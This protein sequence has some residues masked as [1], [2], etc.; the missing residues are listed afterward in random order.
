MSKIDWQNAVKAAAQTESFEAVGKTIEN[1][2]IPLL[3]DVATKPTPRFI[4]GATKLIDDAQA[5]KQF[6]SSKTNPISELTDVFNHAIKEKP[7]AISLFATPHI[8]ITIAK[9]RAARWLNAAL[10]LEAKIHATAPKSQK[11]NEDWHQLLINLTSSFGAICGGADY[12]TLHYDETDLH[13]KRLASNAFK[14][15]QEEGLLSRSLDPAAGSG[16]VESLT[17]QFAETVWKKLGNKTPLPHLKSLLPPTE[18]T[19]SDEQIEVKNFYTKNDLPQEFIES[20]PGAEPFLRGPYAAM[21]LTR[22]WTIR[23]YAGFSTAEDSNAFY[24]HALK[25][26]QKGLSVAFDLPTHRGFD[27]DNKQVANDVGMAGVA[28]DCLEDMRILFDKIPLDKVS[29]SMTMNG[30]V[31]PIMALYI[32]AAAEQNVAPEQLAG[33]IQNDIFKEFMV[34]NTYIY[35]PKESIRIVADIFEYASKNMPKFNTISIS[36]YHMQEA[37]ATKDLELAYTLADGIEYVR[38]GLKTGMDIDAFAHRLSFFWCIG[39]DFFME[40]AKMRAARVL[41]AEIMKGFGAKKEKSLALRTHCQTS[42]WSLTSKDVFN[43]VAR[44]CLE[45]MAAASGGTQSLHT[46]ALD[47]AMALPSDFSAKVARETQIFLQKET[48]LCATIDG[49]GG[50]YY[51]ERLTAD[52][53]GRA[54]K[55]IDEIEAE[56]G[57]VAALAKGIPKRNIEIAATRTQAK[58]DS[59]ERVIVGVN[60]Y[61]AENEPDINILK[62][63]NMAVREK[64]LARLKANRAQRDEAQTLKAL[65]DLTKASRG[66]ENL[67]AACVEAAKAGATVGEMSAAMEKTFTRYKAQPEMIKGVY[68]ETSRNN[69]KLT[70]AQKTSAEFSQHHGFSPHI[71]I[72]KAGQDGHDRGQKVVAAA[73]ADMGFEVSVGALF[74]SASEVANQAIKAG[75]NF[76][77]ISS[78]AGAHLAL[79][80]ELVEELKA[81]DRGDIIVVVG[82]IIPSDDIKP[83]K[84]LGVDRVF[85]PG[86]DISTS[87]IDLLELLR[88]R[89]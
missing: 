30:A 82:G 61:Q 83:L 58:I 81:K 84:D 69:E 42:G 79:A 3:G 12:I 52:M 26:G 43:N 56:G 48:D 36:G 88:G 11:Q 37:G 71:F 73:F 4:F 60:K 23:Q 24:H 45:A 31:L 21:F 34:R 7:Q 40:V 27:S 6:I 5:K 20:M 28:I 85:L 39:M 19:I 41:W 63:D 22:P 89:N 46:N 1:V 68:G 32:V 87:A 80:G 44:T 65:E 50:S 66:K 49:W 2:K 15:S 77:A 35:P 33:T 75:A 70:R 51:L 38:A 57:M 76:V 16:L 17:Q 67:L 18:T 14:L 74:L 8:F 62:I 55:L 86:T 25:N 72:A 54:R 29:V 10:E 78:L 64:Q 59:G 53:M 9:L 13:S 47:E